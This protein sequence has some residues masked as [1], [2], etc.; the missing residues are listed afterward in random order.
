MKNTDDVHG[1]TSVH[2]LQEPLSIRYDTFV[3][4]LCIRTYESKEQFFY[5]FIYYIHKT[6]YNLKKNIKLVTI[7]FW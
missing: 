2:S 4:R 7:K 1:I 3:R 6:L 5:F